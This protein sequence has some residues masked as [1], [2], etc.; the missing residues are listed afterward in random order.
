MG[1]FSAGLLASGFLLFLT[2]AAGLV[3]SWSVV[4]G[5]L[6]L[7]AG[8]VGLAI[9]MEDK[10]LQAVTGRRPVMSEPSVFDPA[11]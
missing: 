10:D 8:G 7:A 2:G 3:A 1:R 5:V 11:A 4:I 9:T 6:L